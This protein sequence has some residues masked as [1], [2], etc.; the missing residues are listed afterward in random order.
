[1]IDRRTGKRRKVYIMRNK[2]SKDYG[3][4]WRAI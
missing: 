3:T 4:T 1:M 2:I